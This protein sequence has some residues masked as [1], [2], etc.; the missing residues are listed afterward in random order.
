MIARHPEKEPGNCQ[1]IYSSRKQKQ[2]RI[3]LP[4]IRMASVPIQVIR[5]S[6]ASSQSIISVTFGPH[7]VIR[8]MLRRMPYC[9]VS[10]VK[11]LFVQA[12]GLRCIMRATLFISINEFFI[13]LPHEKGAAYNNI[14]S[15]IVLQQKYG[16]VNQIFNSLLQR[17]F[18]YNVVANRSDDNV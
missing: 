5:P 12:P 8:R 9:A 18:L 1:Y 3:S 13:R 10:L 4:W 6:L 11:T 7:W 14:R 2:N 17:L 15:E 16:A